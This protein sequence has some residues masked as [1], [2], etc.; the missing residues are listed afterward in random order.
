MTAISARFALPLLALLTLAALPVA[1]LGWAPRQ[2][3]DCANPEALLDFAQIDDRVALKEGVPESGA[4]S[5]FRV[6]AVFEPW[7][8][9]LGALQIALLRDYGLSGRFQNP[10]STI[11]AGFEPD[12]SRI[13]WVDAGPD[14]IPVHLEHQQIDEDVRF[15]AYFFAHAGR[16]GTGP[17]WTRLRSAPRALLTGTRPL[18]MVVISGSPRTSDVNTVEHLAKQLLA[19]IW[20]H[21]RRVCAH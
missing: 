2:I 18:L 1:R 15:A 10:S 12:R 21:Q 5:R 6:D 16:P 20:E 17:F 8:P 3:E 19:S 14:R 11:L 7:N 4:A 13:D 9:N